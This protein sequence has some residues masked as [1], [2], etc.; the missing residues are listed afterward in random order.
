MN[1]LDRASQRPESGT[2]AKH[3][4][5]FLSPLLR[6]A[7]LAIASVA[8]VGAVVLSSLPDQILLG[9]IPDDVAYPTHAALGTV[10]N[11][12]GASPSAAGVQ[13]VKAA[14]HARSP[15]DVTRAAQ[16]LAQARR[17]SR[18]PSRLDATLCAMIEHGNPAVWDAADQAH[19]AC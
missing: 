18:D 3:G 10:L 15:G 12:A 9:S 19:L 17:Y 6:L 16:G 13:W 7:L 8:I 2:R 11:L 5:P 14:S 4:V 1:R